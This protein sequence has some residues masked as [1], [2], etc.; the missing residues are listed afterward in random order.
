MVCS[1][2]PLTIIIYFFSASFRASITRAAPLAFF[3][4]YGFILFISL[5]LVIRAIKVGA[6]FSLI[7]VTINVLRAV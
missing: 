5:W 2:T 7:A 4:I 6:T 1:G 3:V